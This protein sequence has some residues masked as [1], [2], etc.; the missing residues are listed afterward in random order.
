HD[1]NF[2]FPEFD[3]NAVRKPDDLLAFHVE[4]ILLPLSVI[5]FFWPDPRALLV[6][7]AIA[8]ASGAWPAYQIARR[9]LMHDG[10]ALAFPLIYLLSPSLIGASLSDFHPVTLSAA[11]FLWAFDLR[12]RHAYRWYFLFVVLILFLK[13]EMGLL[14][15]MLGLYQLYRAIRPLALP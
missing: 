8:L 7:Q 2:V 14:V 10:L 11:L 5:Y 4:P 3:P 15:A 1:A 6:L 9:H 13:E 12:E